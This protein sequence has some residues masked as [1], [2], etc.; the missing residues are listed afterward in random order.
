MTL[1]RRTEV[2]IDLLVILGLTC[3]I[4]AAHP[5]PRGLSTILGVYAFAGLLYRCIG[6]ARE[7][8]A[9]HWTLAVLLASTVLI[10]AIGTHN[11]DAAGAP[12]SGVVWWIIVHRIITLLLV[13]VWPWLIGRV[14]LPTL[15]VQG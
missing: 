14:R 13:L 5:S 4:I 3:T 6:H 12:A 8:D 1:A 2:V 10:A 7:M 15:P 9:L 11:L